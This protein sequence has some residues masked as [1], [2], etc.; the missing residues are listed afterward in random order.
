VVRYDD[1][2]QFKAESTIIFGDDVDV[3]PEPAKPPVPD[4]AKK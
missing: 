3:T 1:Y 2:K 4:P